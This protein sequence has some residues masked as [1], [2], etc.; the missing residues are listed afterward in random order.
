MTGIQPAAAAAKASTAYFLFIVLFPISIV[1]IYIQDKLLQSYHHSRSSAST[2]SI[3]FGVITTRQKN[4]PSASS[5]SSRKL[6][7]LLAADETNNEILYPKD[8]IG[9]A[10]ILLAAAQTTPRPIPD[11]NIDH[12]IERARCTRYKLNYTPNKTNTRRRIFWG[13]PVADDSWHILS[14]QAIETYGVFHTVAFVESNRTS[15]ADERQLRF[16]NGSLNKGI[17]MGGMFG[18]DTRVGVDYYVNEDVGEGVDTLVSLERGELE[19]SRQSFSYYDL[20]MHIL[21]V[22]MI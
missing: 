16:D 22:L 10:K 2:S 18:E 7:R 12:H 6:S 1:S 21:H 14:I 8:S 3:N 17:L 13:S 11:S 19:F 15:M 5:T 4:R 9:S 20:L